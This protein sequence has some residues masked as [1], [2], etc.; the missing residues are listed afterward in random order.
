M[1]HH[2]HRRIY[3]ADSSSLFCAQKLDKPISNVNVIWRHHQSSCIAI[4][5]SSSP[6]CI[7]IIFVLLLL[8]VQIACWKIGQAFCRRIECQ[9]RRRSNCFAEMWLHCCGQH[10]AV[11]VIKNC[12]ALTIVIQW[13]AEQSLSTFIRAVEKS[14]TNIRTNC[15]VTHYTYDISYKDT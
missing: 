13:K 14:T 7:V 10:I 6:P 9:P 1:H 2:H 3:F 4:N 5:W 11:E 8:I 15:I 12:I